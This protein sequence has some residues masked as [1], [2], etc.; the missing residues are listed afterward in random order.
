MTTLIMTK[1]LPGSGKSTWAK[2]YV[3]KAQP[4]TVVRINKDDMR[5]MLHADRWNPAN[6]RQVVRARDA[7]VEAFL[8]KKV[9]A[10]IVDDT[11]FAPQHET[12][13][14]QLAHRHGAQFEIKDFTDVPLHTCIKR[15]LA[16]E[17]SVGEKVIK[18]MYNQYLKPEPADPPI[19]NPDL[20][21]VVLVDLDGTLAKM[22][23]DRSPFAWD[24]VGEDTPHHD[25]V[26]LVSTLREAGTGIIFV[27]GRDGSCYNQ[28]RAWLRENLGDWSLSSFLF[29]RTPGDMRKDSVVKEEIYQR[30]IAGKYNVWFVLDDRDQVVETWRALGL[31]CLQV[32]PGN[33]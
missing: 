10:V 7:L 5:A 26:D 30:S 22:A 20:R 18:D 25:I 33:F 29:M 31:R 4:G 13:L 9:N 8:V 15:D 32:A 12:R 27:S 14:R 19:Y 16:R 3:L 23:A 1:G 21:D 17:K 6:E 28:T 2:E 24:R 11:N